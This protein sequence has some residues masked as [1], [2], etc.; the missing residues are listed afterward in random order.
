MLLYV[1]DRIL[2]VVEYRSANAPWLSPL[3]LQGLWALLQP[4]Y[5]Q[6]DLAMQLFYV[7]N[8][9]H[10]GAD[11]W[12]PTGYGKD[13]SGDGY[14]NLRFG[15]ITLDLSSIEATILASLDQVIDGGTGNGER[16]RAGIRDVVANAA[17]RPKIEA[18][19]ESRDGSTRGSSR[20][21]S[22]LQKAMQDGSDT[23]IYIH[24]FNNDWDDAVSAAAALQI[25]LNRKGQ[26]PVNVVLF[27]WP[28]D[29][30]SMLYIP[31]FSDRDDASF[32]RNAL[33][34]ALLLLQNKLSELRRET[35]SGAYTTRREYL[36]ALQNGQVDV[37]KIL[38]RNGLHLLCHSMG[39]YVLECALE[40]SR[41]N[42]EYALVDRMFENVFM[43]APDVTTDALEPGK[44]LAQLAHLSQTVSVYYNKQDKPL[45][46][47]TTTK[48]LHERLGR[49]GSSRPSAVDRTFMHIDCTKVVEDGISE[50]GYYLNGLVLQDICD[51]INGERHSTRSYRDGDPVFPNNWS[52][53]AEP[54]V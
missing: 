27:T 47:S 37:D 40:A 2:Y 14:Q 43:C 4:H 34:R 22:E 12:S 38:C 16:I 1:Y 13:P 33:C 45:L 54:G 44:P 51:T 35:I 3:H 30:Q 9:R 20:A 28:S 49:T 19:Q 10:Q 48:H 41:L 7:T 18:F 26:K 53:K 52:L 29:G 39:N 15:C 25:M 46:L 31:Y 24:G 21:Y 50:H 32:S 23:L 36:N 42:P 5:S 11:Q 8:R 6:R 17:T